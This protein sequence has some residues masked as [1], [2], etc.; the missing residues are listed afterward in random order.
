MVRPVKELKA[1]GRVELQ[2]GEAKT[3]T[4]T[5]PVDML[6]FTGPEGYRIVEP[7]EH[8]LQLGA[9]SADIRQRAKVEVTGKTRQL[10]KNWKMESQFSVA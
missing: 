7:G 3:V 2:P 8:E 10:P 4:F 5:V 6:C 1:F 9:S